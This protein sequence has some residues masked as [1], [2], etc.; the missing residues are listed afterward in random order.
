L[1]RPSFNVRLKKPDEPRPQYLG[2]AFW[3]ALFIL[4]LVAFTLFCIFVALY[5]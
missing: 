5:A 3:L 1:S 2:T 4:G